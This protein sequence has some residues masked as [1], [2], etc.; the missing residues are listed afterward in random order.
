MHVKK[1]WHANISHESVVFEKRCFIRLSCNKANTEKF[2][3]RLFSK[4]MQKANS[5]F[6][7]QMAK[8]EKS[9]ILSSMLWLPVGLYLPMSGSTSFWVWFL[10]VSFSLN[11]FKCIIGYWYCVNVYKV[12]AA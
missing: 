12:E 1:T 2:D 5:E 9:N 8:Q 10:R 7:L 6:F 4:K 11:K 3:E